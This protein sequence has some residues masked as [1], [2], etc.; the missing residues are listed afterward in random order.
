MTFEKDFVLND[1]KVLKQRYEESQRQIID[2]NSQL[3]VINKRITQLEQAKN[4][5]EEKS[6]ECHKRVRH[7]ER[8]AANIESQLKELFPNVRIDY[9]RVDDSEPSIQLISALVNKVN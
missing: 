1:N 2:L 8:I 6:E 3:A 4:Q 9:F 5:A 7:A